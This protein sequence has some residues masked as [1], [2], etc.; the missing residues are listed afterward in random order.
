MIR[1]PSQVPRPGWLTVWVLC[2]WNLE[3]M[4]LWPVQCSLFWPD[5]ELCWNY[6]SPEQFLRVIWDA[7]FWVIVLSVA[8]IKLFFLIFF[9]F[10]CGPFLKYLLNLLQ[11]CFCFMFW[12]LGPKARRILAPWPAPPVLEGQ[13]LITGSPGKSPNPYSYYR[14]LTDS[15]QGQCQPT[16][17]G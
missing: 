10:R 4:Y 2:F 17:T 8:Q 12:F 15:F 9:F 1:L 7:G 11:C 6:T 3:G 14:L 16:C 5:V 13:V